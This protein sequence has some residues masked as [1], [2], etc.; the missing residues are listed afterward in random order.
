M[1]RSRP[2]D[3]VKLHSHNIK[4]LNPRRLRLRT[5]RASRERFAANLERQNASLFRGTVARRQFVWWCQKHPFTKM[6]QRF[7]TF[8][9][10]G[11]PGS[12]FTF[13]LYRAPSPRSVRPTRISACVESCLCRANRSE[14]LESRA[15]GRIRPQCDALQC[16]VHW[17]APSV[18]PGSLLG[19]EAWPLRPSTG[20]HSSP[21]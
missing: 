15:T 10:S 17:N 1:C 2:S 9:K 3:A 14:V 20:T 5:A 8:A 18:A 16:R 19:T 4:T 13:F 12:A 11:E 6:A 21:V 7:D